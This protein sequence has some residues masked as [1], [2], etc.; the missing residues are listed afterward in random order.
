MKTRREVIRWLGA[1]PAA[2]LAAQI[3]PI[4]LMAMK[5]A[6]PR[7]ADARTPPLAPGAPL[8]PERMA[9]IAAFKNNPKGLQKSLRRAHIRATG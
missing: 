9:L 1:L 3:D 6:M 2:F 5:W 7:A 4:E 8:S